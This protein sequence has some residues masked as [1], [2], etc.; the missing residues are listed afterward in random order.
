MER[1]LFI[2]FAFNR[3]PPSGPGSGG[4]IHRL[5]FYSVLYSTV[6]GGLALAFFVAVFDVLL[7]VVS[8][9]M[10][11]VIEK[12]AS[13]SPHLA[14]AGRAACCVLMV[15]VP[16]LHRLKKKAFATYHRSVVRTVVVF[17]MPP[18]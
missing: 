12:K 7:L 14:G 2:Y 13:V 5:T 3:A 16:L 11:R 4:G 9:T 10:N 17:T 1:S 15:F 6:V 8:H 18:A